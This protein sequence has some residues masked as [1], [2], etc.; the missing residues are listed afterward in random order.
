MTFYIHEG[1]KKKQYFYCQELF[2]EGNFKS[3]PSEIETEKDKLV[4]W[5]VTL[6]LYKIGICWQ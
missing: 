2:M 1:K 6:F 5:V 4:L 3:L